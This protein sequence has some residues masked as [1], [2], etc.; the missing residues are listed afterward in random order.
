[1]DPGAHTRNIQTVRRH[2][3]SG[4]RSSGRLHHIG[5]QPLRNGR[6]DLGDEVQGGARQRGIAPPGNPLR[7][8]HGRLDLVGRQ[9]QR[10][11]VMPALQHIAD[12]GLP[13]D[14]HPLP[15]Q[16]G[17]V[18]IDRALGGLEL[19]GDRLGR[20]RP[21]GAPQDLDDLEKSVGTSHASSLK[22]PC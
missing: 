16:G 6:A 1:V 7:A 5:A 13:A 9:H 4:R 14:R 12:A 10:R 19:L 3:P 18:A 17:D 22:P 2:P 21:A 8:E 15:D 20:Q 11:Q